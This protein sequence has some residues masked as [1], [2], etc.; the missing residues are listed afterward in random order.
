ML[1][2]AAKFRDAA[3]APCPKIFTIEDAFDK[4]RENSDSGPIFRSLFQ[5]L[6]ADERVTDQIDAFETWF[7]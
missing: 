4:I 6:A 1:Q 7:L 3:Q 2:L 5:R